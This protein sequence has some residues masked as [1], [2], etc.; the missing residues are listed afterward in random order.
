MCHP[1]FDD[2]KVPDAKMPT[3]KDLP[4]LFDFTR[5]EL[6]CRPDLIKNLVP[7]HA[8]QELLSR[9]V[10]VN[11]FDPIPLDQMRVHLD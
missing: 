10:D 2:L 6:S 11:N 8:E 9:G 5:E 4:P 7:A 3:G 1:F